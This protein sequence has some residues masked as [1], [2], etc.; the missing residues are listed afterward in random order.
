MNLDPKVQRIINWRESLALLPDTHFFELVRM[1][2]GEVKTP[3]NKQKLIEELGA[4]LRKEENKKNLITFLSKDDIEIITAVKFIPE[5]TQENLGTFFAGT[6]SYADLY[7]TILNLEERLILYRHAN[8]NETKTIIDINPLLEE[9]L[10]PFT[11]VE[12]LLS[13]SVAAVKFESIPFTVNPQFISAFISFA[14]SHKDMFK[15]DNS[16]KKRTVTELRSLYGITDNGSALENSLHLLADALW[17]LNIFQEDDESNVKINSLRLDGFVSLPSFMQYIYLCTASCGHFSRT[18]LRIYAQLLLNTLSSIPKDGLTKK[19]LLRL[20]Y[21]IKGENSFADYS[22]RS[23]ININ[24]FADRNAATGDSGIME[25][26]CDAAISFGLLYV[27]GKDENEQD[28]Y[29]VSPLFKADDSPIE[30]AKVLSID[31]GF[32]ITIMPGLSLGQMISLISFMN[33]VR[34]DTAAVFE[35]TKAS[36]M[37]AFDAGITP[38]KIF[39]LLA[40]YSAYDI[41]PNFKISVEEWYSSFSSAALYKGYIL[42][43]NANN[44]VL[45]EKNPV[46]A[47]Y[48]KL[49]LSDG[50]YLLDIYSDEEAKLLLHKSGLDFIGNIKSFEKNNDVLLLP[51]LEPD[52][53]KKISSLCKNSENSITEN[54]AKTASAIPADTKNQQKL[55]A[56]LHKE[57]NSMEMASEQKEG[58]SDRIDR[59]IILNAEQLRPTSVRFEVL[60]ATGMDYS[61]KIHVIENA[62]DNGCMIEFS[63]ADNSNVVMATPVFLLNKKTN[64]SLRLTTEPDKAELEIPV[65]TIQYVKKLR[66]SVL[67]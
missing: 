17:N 22:N 13:K 40:Q 12:V 56:S 21:L 54:S 38:E 67:K 27:C 33:C 63:T 2:L 35:I 47:P 28:I 65:G 4:F 11:G 31:A 60:E 49:K 3:Y 6:Y 37:R 50:I 48:I 1:Y 55:L 62:I 23:Y 8:T 52:V 32:S 26:L 59:R 45:T 30:N 44:C 39:S 16:F 18:S 51:V 9:V 29:C 57:L 10:E 64:A 46:L 20:S 61:G 5:A 24:S 42:K 25:L 34:Y 43:V 66:G 36:V 53:S 15:A 19:S 41:P 14:A 7:E 58:L